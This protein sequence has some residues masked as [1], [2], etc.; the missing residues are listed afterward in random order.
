VKI[1]IDLL[2][3]RSKIE[4]KRRG[5]C[6]SL[7]RETHGVSCFAC[8]SSE[9]TFLSSLAQRLKNIAMGFPSSCKYRKESCQRKYR[10]RTTVLSCSDNQPW[11]REQS[12]K[13][14]SDKI[15]L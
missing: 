5:G 11:T 6:F 8:L 7:S 14:N 3:R 12:F 10:W 4:R 2:G 1:N 13:L 9:F 15:Q